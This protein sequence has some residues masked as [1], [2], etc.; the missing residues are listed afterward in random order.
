[1]GE[2]GNGCGGNFGDRFGLWASGA[3]RAALECAAG[4][5]PDAAPDLA[6]VVRV[7][8]RMQDLVRW[9]ISEQCATLRGVTGL[10]P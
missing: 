3:L 1:M 7:S 9:G 2:I 5:T 8:P 4:L 10:G 6:W